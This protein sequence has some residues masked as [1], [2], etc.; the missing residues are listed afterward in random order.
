MMDA[1]DARVCLMRHS[2]CLGVCMAYRASW[3]CIL[4]N[5]LAHRAPKQRST[6]EQW[7]SKDECAWA[8]KT[9]DMCLEGGLSPLAAAACS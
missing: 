7:P 3:G 2:K 1:Q 5:L 9:H 6:G 8:H 4:S